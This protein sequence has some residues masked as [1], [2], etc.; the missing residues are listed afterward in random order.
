MHLGTYLYTRFF[1][2]LVG[3]DESKNKYFCKI[4]NNYCKK[5]TAR[6]MLTA[7]GV[8]VGVQ[9]ELTTAYIGGVRR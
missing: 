8:W 3:T 7:S 2:N 9:Q 1:G 6:Q 4:D 5:N